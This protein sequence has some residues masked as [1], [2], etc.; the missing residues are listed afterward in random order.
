M[1]LECEIGMHVPAG[2]NLVAFAFDDQHAENN[3]LRKCKYCDKYIGQSKGRRM[4]ISEQNAKRVINTMRAVVLADAILAAK[5]A[6]L[7]MGK[8]GMSDG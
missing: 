7:R 2:K 4:I 1:H 6:Q 3:W 5:V 8:E